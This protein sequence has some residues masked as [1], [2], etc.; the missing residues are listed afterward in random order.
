MDGYSG[1]LPG[2]FEEALT[3]WQ[4]KRPV[5]ILGGFGG[6]A[7]ILADAICETSGDPPHELTL[8]WH[9]QRNPAL[10]TLLDGTRQFTVP[11][12][13]HDIEK[14]FETLSEFVM[15]ARENLSDTLMTGLNEEQNRELLK[16]GN[17]TNAVRLVRSGLNI[18]KNWPSSAA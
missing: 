14:S 17:I 11:P 16:T 15:R 13:L 8:D 9:K 4:S 10:A 7:E 18:S 2:I 3:T 12:G 5:Y 1:F 6:A